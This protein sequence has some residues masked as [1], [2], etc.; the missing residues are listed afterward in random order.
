LKFGVNMWQFMPLV[1]KKIQTD[2]DT[3][4]HADGWHGGALS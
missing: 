3:E 4:K 2:D 1:V